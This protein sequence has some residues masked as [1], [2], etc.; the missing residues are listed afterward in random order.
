VQPLIEALKDENKYVRKCAAEA[1]GKLGDERLVEPLI[2]ALS[3]AD[4]FV[5]EK[6]AAALGKVGDTRAIGPLAVFIES[7][8]HEHF[9]ETARAALNSIK[10]RQKL[11]YS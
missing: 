9:R 10:L 7:L 8:E 4:W 6:A 5:Q 11:R 2:E 3:D 1:C